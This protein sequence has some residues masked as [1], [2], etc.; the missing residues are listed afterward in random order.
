MQAVARRLGIRS[1]LS[2]LLALDLALIS[3]S[4]AHAQGSAA[5]SLVTDPIDEG[6]VVRPAGNTR[7]EA[8]ARNDRG[9]V[10]DSM[11]L[12][13]MLLLLKRPAERELELQ[14]FIRQLHDRK[15]PFYHHW[16][17]AVEFGRRF[18]LAQQDL[19]TITGWL[20]RHGFTVNAVYPGGVV[21]D[22]SGTAGGVRSAFRTEIHALEVRGVRHIAN[23]SDP[24]IPAALAPAVAGIVSLHDFRPHP[25]LHRAHAAFTLSSSVHLVVPA[26]LA[27]IYNLNPLFTSGVTGQGQTVAVVEDSDVYSTTDWSTFRSVFGLAGYPGS[28]SEASEVH[29]GGCADP[30]V[31]GDQ[32]EAILDAE[33]A[34]AAAPGAAI[35]LA[36]CANS[37]TTPG[38][39]LAAENLIASASPPAIISISYAGCEADNGLTANQAIS[40]A[41]QQA[42]GEGVS[43]FVAAGDWGAA[44][45]DAGSGLKYATQGIA[46]NGLASTAYN[47]AVGGTDFGDYY[48]NTT[49]TYW[50]STNNSV[51]GSA[52]SYIPEIPWNESCA[53][54]LIATFEG[55]S[56]TYGSSGFCNTKAGASYL[57]FIAGSGGPSGCAVQGMQSDTCAGT[58]KPSWQAGPGVPSDGV[59]DLPDVSLF[60]S[61]GPWGHAYVFCD[62]DGSICS[63]SKSDGPSKWATAGGTSFATPILAGIQALVNQSTGARQGNPNFVYYTLA[64]SQ[65]ASGLKCNSTSGNAVSSGCVF[66]DI[67]Q[68]DM[69][70]VCEGSNDCYLPSG[71]YGV[72]STNDGAYAAAFGATSGWDFATGL[73]S[74]NAANLVKYWTSSDVS[75]SASG[76]VIAGGLLSYSLTVGDRGPQTATAVVVSTTLPAGLTLVS[77]MSS[78]FCTQSGQT[79]TCAVGALAVGATAPITIVLVPSGSGTVNLQFTASS[80]NPDL[81]PADGSATVA[82]NASGESSGSDGP[83]PLWAYVAL[84]LL[85]LG[86]ATRPSALRARPR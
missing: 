67:T 2:G 36:A 6:R 62:S 80:G 51:Y 45:C 44:V 58:P 41:Y 57:D 82:L 81:N 19:A 31:T 5:R 61:D 69:D 64:A 14:H 33:W 86:I 50:S 56:P 7:S 28:F 46:V 12:E 65:S 38:V 55:Y 18:G 26:D 78:P 25:T 9:R 34:S 11:P 49:S 32:D 83:L 39:F 77:G 76:T 13:H 35:E 3:G 10:P 24:Q 73:G 84:G 42:A 59:R 47:V 15:S 37:S 8:N 71:T 70:V 29:P 75:L 21:I 74:V 22:F 1:V 40:S 43:V 60:A 30:G 20:T 4:P 23:M 72:L 85:L 68:G 53:S 48:A 66:Y 79:L 54:V 27:T 63:T 16:L 17:S 52:L